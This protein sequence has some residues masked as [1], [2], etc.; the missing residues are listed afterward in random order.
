MVHEPEPEP[1]PPF[2]DAEFDAAAI[3][4]SIQYL[5]RPAAVLRDLGRVLAPAARW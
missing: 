5:T 4:V 1:A 3:C 2:A